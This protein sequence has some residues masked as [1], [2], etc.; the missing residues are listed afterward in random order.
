M[1]SSRTTNVLP[2]DRPCKGGRNKLYYN[3]HHQ[4]LLWTWHQVHSANRWAP[5]HSLHFKGVDFIDDTKE[6]FESR[7]GPFDFDLISWEELPG[8][9]ISAFS[10]TCSR[11]LTNLITLWTEGYS[12]RISRSK[13]R[14]ENVGEHL[15]GN[16][17]NINEATS[18]IWSEYKIAI[19]SSKTDRKVCCSSWFSDVAT[20]AD[21]CL[22]IIEEAYIRGLSY[23]S[24]RASQAR[25][26]E[27]LETEYP[28]ITFCGSAWRHPIK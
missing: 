13:R 19:F 25:V 10:R 24:T 4:T 7:L 5:E 1:Q 3:D 11:D 28:L 18:G 27:S 21:I 23:R 15:A 17:N 6:T 8:A 2:Q 22:L 9:C 16:E 20:G 26:N 12:S 14:L